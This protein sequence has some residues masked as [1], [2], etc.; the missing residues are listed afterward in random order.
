VRLSQ[1]SPDTSLQD[2]IAVIARE[3][4]TG[5]LIVQEEK[6]VGLVTQRDILLPLAPG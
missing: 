4:Q 6:L 2:V 5:I 3:G 1:V